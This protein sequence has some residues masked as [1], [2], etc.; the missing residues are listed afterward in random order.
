VAAGGGFFPPLQGL[1]AVLL[2]ALG[3]VVALAEIECRLRGSWGGGFEVAKG[4]LR[5]ALDHAAAQIGVAD[6]VHGVGISRVSGAVR[7][8]HGGGI[9]FGGAFS[10]A[11][12]HGERELRGGVAFLSFRGEFGNGGGLAGGNGGGAGEH[13]EGNG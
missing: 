1:G 2:R 12:V 3:A 5:L 9:V 8:A 11:I 10:V 4:N 6:E 7:P 13:E